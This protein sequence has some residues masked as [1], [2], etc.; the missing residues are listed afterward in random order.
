MLLKKNIYVIEVLVSDNFKDI[1]LLLSLFILFTFPSFSQNNNIEFKHLSSDDGLS[2]NFVSCILQD[3]KGFMWFGTKDGLNRYDGHTF[4]VYQHDP[5]DTTTISANYITALYEDSRGYIWIGTLNGGLNC[6][7]RNTEIFHH[8]H[9]SS[10]GLDNFNTNE[11]KSIAE[12]KTGNVW[13]AT[14]NDGLFKITLNH[15]NFYA[16][17]YKQYI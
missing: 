16:A 9:Y 4:A 17:S 2:Q 15:K 14:R 5:F 12:D 1:L 11:I 3:Q 10:F 13:V 8:I 6:F 7:D